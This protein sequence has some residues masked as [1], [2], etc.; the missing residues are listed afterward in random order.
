VRQQAGDFL[1][2]AQVELESLF[3][4]MK[5]KISR[6]VKSIGNAATK[7][8]SKFKIVLV[9]LTAVRWLYEL[10]AWLFAMLQ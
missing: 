9:I 3:K 10:V 1:Q 4:S 6:S 2:R 8:A 7:Y 5:L